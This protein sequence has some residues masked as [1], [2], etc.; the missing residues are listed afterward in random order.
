MFLGTETPKNFASTVQ[1]IDSDRKED[2]KTTIS[3]NAP[4]RYVGETFY[5][6]GWFPG[7]GGTVLQVV[8]NPGW[9]MPYVSCVMVALGMIIHFGLN[10]LKFLQ[11]RMAL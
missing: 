8:N 7:D 10:L 6:S 3:M 1:L 11:R 4:L 9:L 2:R 5:Q